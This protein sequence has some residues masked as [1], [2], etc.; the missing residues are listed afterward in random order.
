MLVSRWVAEWW[1]LSY[2]C[3]IVFINVKLVKLFAVDK[4]LNVVNFNSEKNIFILDDFLIK[5]AMRYFPRL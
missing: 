1:M 4:H 2:S 3:I 5:K